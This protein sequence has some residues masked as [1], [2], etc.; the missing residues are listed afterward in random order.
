MMRY[1]TYLWKWLKF[2]TL[3]TSHAGK[4]RGFIADENLKWYSQFGRQYGSLLQNQTYFY[5][6]GQQSHSLVFLQ[7]NQKCYIHTKTCTEMFTA[8]LFI[9]AKSCKKPRRPSVDEWINKRWHIWMMGCYSVL[10][11]KK[12]SSREKTWGELKCSLLSERSSGILE[13]QNYGG[14]K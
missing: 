8:L 4:W 9:I 12:L 6:T 2:E 3:T 5:Y 7:M 10:K 14:R 11:R 13:R 1:H